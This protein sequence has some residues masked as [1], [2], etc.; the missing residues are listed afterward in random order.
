MLFLRNQFFTCMESCPKCQNRSF[1]LKELFENSKIVL[2]NCCKKCG[3]EIGRQ[4]N[5]TP[6]YTDDIVAK[7][8]KLVGYKFTLQSIT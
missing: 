6:C 1:E 4:E 2:A 3:F 7:Y 8:E 5:Y